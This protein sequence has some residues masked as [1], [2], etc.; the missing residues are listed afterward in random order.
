MVLKVRRYLPELT[1]DTAILSGILAVTAVVYLR[2]LENAFVLD[3]VVQIIKNPDLPDWSFLWKAFTRNEFWY[4]DAAFVHG[5]QSRNYRPIIL[6]WY[7]VNYH[8][9]GLHPA[10][11]HWSIVLVHLVAVWL[12]FKIARRLTG[13]STSALFAAGIFAFLPVH[14]GTVVWMAACG[15]V[16]GTA[17]VLGSFYVLIRSAD[18]SSRDWILAVLLFAGALLCHESMAVYPAVVASYAFLFVESEGASL[19]MRARRAVILTA[20]FALELLL[21]FITRKLVLGFFVKN[22]GDIDNLLTGAQAV[23]TIP[24]VLMSYMTVLTMPWLTIPNHAIFPV[25]SLASH[26]FWIPLIAFVLI[27]FSFLVF[28]VISAAR[29]LYL[30]CAAWI[31]I[32][33][34]PMLMLQSVPHLVQDYCL[35]LP[36]V[37]WSI[38]VGELLAAV[39]RRGAL[40]RRFAFAGAAAMLTIYAVALWRAEGFW[41]DD[42]AAAT[43]YVEGFPESVRWRW[44]L[45]TYLDRDGDL[46]GSERE[47][48]TALSLEPDRTGII[49]PHSNQLHHYLG[50]LLARRGDIDGAVSELGNSIAV[51]PDD[52][53]GLATAA[54]P[55][56]VTLY[57]RGVQAASAGH[58][59][60]A[61]REITEALNTMRSNPVADDR[62]LALRY[63]KLVELYDSQGNHAQVE[64]LLKQ[65]DSMSE[66]ELAIGLARAGICL[67]HADTECAESIL[68]DLS[69]RYPTNAE[70]LFMLGD[71]EFRLK[72]YD[73]ALDCYR[74]AGGGWFGDS[75]EHLSMAKSLHALGRQQDALDQCRLAEAL[76]PRNFAVQFSCAQIRNE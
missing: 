2:T 5:Y 28:A 32:T 25:S 47:I 16:I 65:L 12:V 6:V 40:A 26:Q 11:W 35:Y 4:S 64:S 1:R 41:H 33:M 13:D 15:M 75:R 48:K 29:R 46:A 36:S 27:I 67:N 72:N 50:E 61:I 56:S 54:E 22:P 17:F 66:G 68:R 14:A 30:F 73:Q 38:L 21:Y 60:L 19:W 37:G 74:R 52:D 69:R 70:V 62:P 57:N 76:D 55:A 20:P 7:W 71:L 23:L 18:V 9:F 51:P 59:E 24:A 31:A 42:V 53:E 49:H 45:A 10:P 63:V 39:A 3:D 8:L 43:G 58:T 44:A 34:I